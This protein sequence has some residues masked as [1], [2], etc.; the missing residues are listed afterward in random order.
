MTI[1]LAITSLDCLRL[2]LMPSHEFFKFHLTPRPPPRRILRKTRAK[3]VLEND[4]T[5]F[6]YVTQ[7]SQ[8]LTFFKIRH[9]SVREGHT[10]SDSHVEMT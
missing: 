1:S 10:N 3:K 4:I 6:D 5:A 9:H 8:P 2:K 7:S